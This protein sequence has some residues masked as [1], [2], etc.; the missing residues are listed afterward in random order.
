MHPLPDALVERLRNRQAVL[1]A[2]AGCSELAQLPGWAAL[3]QCFLEWV[4]DDQ[5]KAA[6]ADL[7]QKGRLTSALALV[8]ELFHESTLGDVLADAYGKGIRVPDAIRT[9][10]HAPW[11][12]L[13]TTTFDALWATA[14]ADDAEVTSRTAFAANASSL[15]HGHG[16]FLLQIFGR[17]DVPASLC[18][19]PAEIPAKIGA[20]GAA[21]FVAGLYHKWSLVFVGYRPDDPDLNLLVQRVLGA[22]ETR[23]P[24]FLLAPQLSDS[25]AR[26]VRAELGLV[27]V[28]LDASLQETLAALAAI[29]AQPGRKPADDEV[30]SWLELFV[31]DPGDWEAHDGLNRGLALLRERKEWERMVGIMISRAEVMHEPAAQAEALREVALLLDQELAATDRA[32]PVMMTA[33]RLQPRDADLLADAKRLAEKAGQWDD[34]ARE[35][36]QLEHEGAD[37]ADSTQIAL[38]VARVC[39]RDTARVD[40]AIAAFQKVLDR[41]PQNP[42]ALAE[43]ENLFR[44]A[45]RWEP[46]RALYEKMLA[47]DPNNNAAFANLEALLRKTEQWA[48]L[49]S[50]LEK[51][52]ARNPADPAALAKL[53]ELYRKTEQW[54]ALTDLL[55]KALARNPTDAAIFGKLEQ[56]YRGT[57][58]WKPLIE[59]LEALTA[60]N[61]ANGE[62]LAKLEE[63]YRKT[64]QWTLLCDLLEMRAQRKGDPELARGL[65]M[66][67]A[68]L[69]LDKLKDVESALV[70]A[71]G[72]TAE[73]PAAAEALYL[74]ALDSDPNH[75]V[76]LAALADLCG[77]KGEFERAAKFALQGAEKTQNPMEKGRLLAQAGILALDRLDDAEGGLELLNRAVAID[78]EQVSAAERLAKL[79]EAREEWLLL[80]PLL[81]M[82]L[83]RAPTDHDAARALLHERVA[84]CA[85]QLGKIDKALTNFEAATRLSPHS[86]PLAQASADLHFEREAWAA[87]GA[88]YERVYALGLTSLSAPERAALCVRMAIC[89]ERIADS[90]AVIHFREEAA[91]LEPHKRGH[92]EA[93]IELRS[94][95]Q[96]WR[97]VVDLRRK[98]LALVGD[99]DER[100]QLWDELGDILREKLHDSADAVACYTKALAIQ[101]ERRQTLY[102]MLDYYS[103]GK[104]WAKA[105]E[106][107]E[108]LSG[109]ETEPTIR[110]RCR[111]TLAAIY[112]D[113]VKDNAKAVAVFTQVLEDDPMFVRAFDAIERMLTESRSWKDLARAYRR[114]LKRLPAEAP[115]EF[116]LRL[117][118]ALAA[119]AIKH[120]KNRE[121]AVLA[122]EV[123]AKLDHDNFARQEQL[124]Q[125]YQESGPSAVNKTIAQHQ[126]LIS[127]RPDRVA[128]YQA[129][130]PLF[131]QMGAH[132][133]MWC[134]AAALVYLGKADPPLASFYESYRPSQLPNLAGKM[135]EELWRKILHPAEDPYIGA[136]LGLLGPAIAMSSASP[137]KAVGLDRGGRI[138]LSGPAWPHAAALRYVANTI[139]ATLPDVF[140]KKDAPGTV[141]IVNLKEKNTLT[142]ALVVGP[143]FDQWS[144]QSEVI[145][146]LAKRMVLMRWERFPRFALGT[147]AL[148]EIAVRAGL[149]L[150]GSPIGNGPHGDEVDKMAKILDPLLL[151]ALRA[152]L[153]VVAKR[154]VEARGDKLD[155]LAWIVA[156]DLTAGRAALTLCGDLGAAARVIAVEPSGQSPLPARERINDLLAFSVSEDHFAVRA[157]LGLH[158]N[159][160]PSPPEAGSLA[161]ASRRRVSHVQIKSTP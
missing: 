125:L 50:L 155:M 6:L 157:A 156:A 141:S 121:S 75:A 51:E 72:F 32:Y 65:R 116:K 41:D 106:T 96:E 2:G 74:R 22:S 86:L 7:L 161:T 78:P 84:L 55:R 108:T 104:Q 33:L 114:Q 101:P 128:S 123:A 135:N 64:E 110:A 140:L 97:E 71:Q 31:A 142:P 87:A 47:R 77:R 143:G 91:A 133:R 59:M 58:Q 68:S 132:D 109:L 82:L 36:A 152:E 127:K 122:L 35:V 69:L 81:D 38:G 63:L 62:A 111:Y 118:D 57:E 4:T 149:L 24:H 138:D 136:L 39:A 98:Q 30:E 89:A 93:L 61:P 53:E 43:L 17:A 83:R 19:S 56:I 73:D 154:F 124:A 16:R 49:T 103:Q 113:E 144:R 85:K 44:Q 115:T 120:L 126:M 70:V 34:F 10:A 130:A 112:R 107:L 150:G 27:P 94:A 92:V 76:A 25:D 13:I 28:S 105:V 60:R 148:L 117:W 160:T 137:H 11:R 29:A 159:L 67:R 129:L 131:Y 134:V 42:E 139:E 158:V 99:E 21:A 14:L 54:K 1:V 20:T 100:A 9:V 5:D 147:P 45:E 145:F 95:R 88:A 119:V 151:P 8:R 153:K 52:L 146:D 48:P 102:K 90:E 37:A 12:G 66:E 40:E 23:V 26:L 46:L 15:E 79:R 18:L 3:G 80:E